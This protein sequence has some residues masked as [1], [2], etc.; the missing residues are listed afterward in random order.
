[1]THGA[2]DRP[3]IALLVLVRRPP[4]AIQ[5]WPPI[6]KSFDCSQQ[7]LERK[8]VTITRPAPVLAH[9]MLQEPSNVFAFPLP[10]PNVP[11]PPNDSGNSCGALTFATNHDGMPWKRTLEQLHRQAT[12]LVG[13]PRPT[14]R[15]D[16]MYD[17]STVVRRCPNSCDKTCRAA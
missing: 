16:P 7:S 5:M 9:A 3:A 11:A 12:R 10:R 6:L 8:P 13:V 17:T 4:G 14:H 1:M 2:Q 15:D